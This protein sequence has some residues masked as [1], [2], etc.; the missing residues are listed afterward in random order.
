MAAST[1]RFLLNTARQVV[2]PRVATPF[3]VSSRRGNATA[4][5]P[6][7]KPKPWSRQEVQEVYDTPLFE[8]IFR[9]VRPLSVAHFVI[10]SDPT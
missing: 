7:N 1:P 5:D 3:S 8:L 2:R 4:V 10:L 6:L 9:A